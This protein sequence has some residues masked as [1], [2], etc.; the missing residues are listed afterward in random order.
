VLAGGSA[1]GLEAASGVRRYLERR[2]K[3]VITPAGRV[4]IVPAAILYDLGIGK[5]QPRPDLAMG[6][7]A[8][9]AATTE[10]VAEGCVGAG[11]GATVGKALGFRQAMKSGMGSFTPRLD[12]QNQ[13]KIYFTT[14]NQGEQDELT[15]LNGRLTWQSK[16]EQWEVAL[17]GDNLT[18]EGYFNGKLNLVGFFG[19]EQGNPGAPRTWGLS[20]KR[21][22]K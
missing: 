8:A 2:G 9:A 12:L 3:G 21:T 19:R 14:N 6:E 17:Y 1:F 18:D 7:A 15:L 16:S 4:P 5:P 11:T 20:F 13:S 22:F 10:S